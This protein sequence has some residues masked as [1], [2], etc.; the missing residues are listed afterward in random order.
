[1]FKNSPQI[2][3]ISKKKKNRSGYIYLLALLGPFHSFSGGLYRTLH[4]TPW[5]GRS[6]RD[7]CPFTPD[8][9]PDRLGI[10]FPSI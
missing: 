4:Y 5:S 9:Q 7:M 1:M 2:R 8:I 10:P 6:K 3:S